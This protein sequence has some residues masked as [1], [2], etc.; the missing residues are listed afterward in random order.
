MAAHSSVLAWE[1]HGQR[2]LTG[3]SPWGR[4][5]SDT[6]ECLTHT[7]INT[8]PPPNTGPLGK[9]TLSLNFSFLYCKTELI[10]GSIIG[11][12]WGLVRKQT[13][14]NSL[15]VQ[16]L[17]LGVSLPQPQVWSLAGEL[18]SHKPCS[19]AKIKRTCG[20]CGGWCRARAQY[21]WAILRSYFPDSFSWPHCVTITFWT[22]SLQ[23]GSQIWTSQCQHTLCLPNYRVTLD[24]GPWG[25]WMQMTAEDKSS[26]LLINHDLSPR[27]EK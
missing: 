27:N 10:L 2:S 7:H 16:W 13:C 26:L 15:A 25:I 22:K 8:L 1:F 6:T 21:I 19:M 24:T 4:K 23:S 3:Y 17:G 20:A 11:F 5:E 14:G 9:A 18:K 12:M